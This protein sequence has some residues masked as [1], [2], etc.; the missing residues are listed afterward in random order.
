MLIADGTRA[1]GGGFYF[2]VEGYTG[3]WDARLPHADLVGRRR[4]R[5]SGR[6]LQHDHTHH[7]L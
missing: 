6:R 4:C 3:E 7:S 1:D 2:S 5:R